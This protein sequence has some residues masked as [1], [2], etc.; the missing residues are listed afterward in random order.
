MSKGFSLE[1]ALKQKQHYYTEL[2]KKG[3]AAS[4]K[5][6]NE[7]PDIKRKKYEQVSKTKRERKTIKYWVDQGYTHEQTAEQIKKYFTPLH[8]LQSFIDRHGEKLGTDMY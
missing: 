1:E 5:I 8:T 4:I 7:N 6:L 3:T 2:N